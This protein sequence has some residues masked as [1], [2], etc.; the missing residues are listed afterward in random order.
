MG[1]NDCIQASRVCKASRP[2]F[3]RGG[4]SAVCAESSVGADAEAVFDG[5]NLYV[6]LPGCF[7]HGV[8]QVRPLS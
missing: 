4:T 7:V 2:E 8:W 1:G 5:N 3:F 6:C